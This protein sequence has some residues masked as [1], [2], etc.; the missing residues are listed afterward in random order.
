MRAMGMKECVLCCVIAI[1]GV[2]WGER[3]WAAEEPEPAKRGILGDRFSLDTGMKFWVAKWQPAGFVNGINS[4]RTSDTTVMMGPSITGSARLRDDEL[5]NSVSVNFTWLQAGGFDFTPFGFNNGGNGPPVDQTSATRRDYSIVGAL[6]IW[7]GFGVFAGYYNMQQRFST[8][9]PGAIKGPAHESVYIS[10]PLIGLFGSGTVSGP[11]KAYGNLA[12]G[13][14]DEKSNNNASGQVQTTAKGV[15]GYS[16]E[17]G[18]SLDGPS[19]KVGGGAIGSAIQAG[20]RAQVINV[21]Q[22][23][24]AN[25]D[26][27]WGPTFQIVAR[28]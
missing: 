25:N 22:G 8:Q 27:T 4:A 14:Y 3:V 6:S 2:A 11:L 17:F 9:Y 13:F 19:L 16:G 21:N 10:G 1:V 5:F 7:R 24:L 23:Q 20:F 26:V 15:Q 28:F 18:L 12:I